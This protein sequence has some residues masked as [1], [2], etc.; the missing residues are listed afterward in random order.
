MKDDPST[1]KL[2]TLDRRRKDVLNFAMINDKLILTRI[3][4]D[5]KNYWTMIDTLGHLVPIP[6]KMDQILQE[7]D[8]EEVYVQEY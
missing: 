8:W 6:Q 4:G 7:N 3:K 5:D 2:C 1:R